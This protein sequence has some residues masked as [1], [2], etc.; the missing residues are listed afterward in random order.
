MDTTRTLWENTMILSNPSRPVF[1]PFSRLA[2]KPGPRAAV[3]ALLAETL[4]L[5]RGAV[6]LVEG[7]RDRRKRVRLAGDP[8]LLAERLA[9]LAASC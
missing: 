4:D 3:L 2:S 8:V 6:T 1:K 7:E 9:A 5:P